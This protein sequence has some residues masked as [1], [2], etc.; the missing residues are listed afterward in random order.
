MESLKILNLFRKP[1]DEE[2]QKEID[3][4]AKTGKVK[5]EKFNAGREFLKY[6]TIS[7]ITKDRK[8]GL[9]IREEK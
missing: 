3:K 5:E 2:V 9:N 1:T 6:K 7:L 8:N 4:D